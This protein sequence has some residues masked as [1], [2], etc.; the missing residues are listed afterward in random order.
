MFNISNNRCGTSRKHYFEK[1]IKKFGDCRK[2]DEV[3]IF[4]MK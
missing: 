1:K 4:Q 2:F 3:Y